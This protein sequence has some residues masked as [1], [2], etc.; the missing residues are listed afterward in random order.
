MKSLLLTFSL[1]LS[2]VSFAAEVMIYEAPA[3]KSDVV[4]AEFE[5]NEKLGR[6]WV[7]I[8]VSDRHD[9]DDMGQWFR[10]KVEGLQYDASAKAAYLDIEGQL[11]ECAVLKQ[12]GVLV[13][14]HNYLKSTGCGF[15]SK[16]ITKEV[17]DGFEI[18]RRSFLQVYLVTKE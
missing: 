2:T 18:K 5:L 7:N 3:W 14:R 11:V 17:D 10:T 13:F 16:Y 6:I 1:L 12:R 8:H 15:K 4:S 9:V